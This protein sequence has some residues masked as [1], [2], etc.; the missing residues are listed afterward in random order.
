MKKKT[1]L[2]ILL[3]LPLIVTG[4]LHLFGK[5]HY[6][7]QNKDLAG[8]SLTGPVGQYQK[9]AQ[10]GKALV[11][12]L[13]STNPTPSDALFYQRVFE[14]LNRIPA[15]GPCQPI[16]AGPQGIL[17]QLKEGTYAALPTLALDSL[18]LSTLATRVKLSVGAVAANRGF[19]LADSKGGI[20]NAYDLRREELM[21]TLLLEALMVAEG[22]GD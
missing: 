1:F 2:F 5:N 9:S 16:I 15:R 8:L 11:I 4:F 17:N 20:V 10:N 21:D 19:I 3:I 7:V 13:A 12:A 18:T 22:A 6:R 14:R